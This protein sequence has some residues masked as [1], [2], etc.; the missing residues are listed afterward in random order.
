MFAFRGKHTKLELTD[1]RDFWADTKVNMEAVVYPKD[2]QSFSEHINR[3]TFLR[4]LDEHGVFSLTYRLNSPT[5]PMYVNLVAVYADKNH[6]VISV[7][8]VDAQVRRE[9]KIREEA[10]ANYEKARHDDLT[11]IRNKNAYNEFEKQLD[12]Q[13]KCGKDIEFAI[14]LCD[15]NGLKT[16]NDTQ[17]HKTG[18]MYIRDAAKLICETF[19]RSP[20][21]RVGGDEFV[22][23]LL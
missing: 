12:E 20:V 13:I 11:G 19:E 5:G 4:E 14:A 21:F 6:V 1:T 8:N 15:V 23:D 7:T 10:S 18:D 17:G 3:E 22:V 2:N 16:V 9:Q